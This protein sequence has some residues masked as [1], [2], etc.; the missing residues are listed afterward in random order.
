MLVR[1]LIRKVGLSQS[2]VAKM[3]KEDAVDAWNKY[4]SEGG[5]VMLSKPEN[6]M[7]QF[8]G[9]FTGLYEDFDLEEERQSWD[10]VPKK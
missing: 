6:P 7:M 10:S 4:L 1:N 9:M 5:A 2:Q 3:S 8:A